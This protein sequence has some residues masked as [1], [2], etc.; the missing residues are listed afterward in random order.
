MKKPKYKGRGN[1]TKKYV[2]G[3]CLLGAALII[4]LI[5]MALAQP[6]HTQGTDVPQSTSESTSEISESAVLYQNRY[7]ESAHGLQL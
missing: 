7:K 2:I 4:M 5:A 6:Q 1:E 3:I